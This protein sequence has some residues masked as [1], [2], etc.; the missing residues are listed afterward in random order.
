MLYVLIDWKT[1]NFELFDFYE[2]DKR[3]EFFI[4]EQKVLHYSLSYILEIGSS[5]VLYQLD[6]QRFNLS[7]EDNI[8]RVSLGLT[9]LGSWEKSLYLDDYLDLNELHDPSFSYLLDSQHYA[10]E[11]VHNRTHILI[12][13]ETSSS[14]L[15]LV[16]LFFY[17][18]LQVFDEEIFQPSLIRRSSV[19][20]EKYEIMTQ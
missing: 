14:N 19:G 4:L 3:I 17:S 20:E 9:K 8:L 13:L 5:Q 7:L 2:I 12:D 15:P 10:A 16:A 18:Q 6:Y 11:T 1:P